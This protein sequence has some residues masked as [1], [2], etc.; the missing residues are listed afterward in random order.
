MSGESWMAP[1]HEFRDWL[2]AIREDPDMR[3]TK[4]R[5]G[6]VKP[7]QLGPFT[8]QARK[9][10]LKRLLQ[11]EQDVGRQ[12]ITDQEILYIQR[13]WT[14]DYD[15]AE[16]A[17]RLAEKFGRRVEAMDPITLPQREQEILE[18]LLAEYEIQPEL[19]YHLLSLVKHKYPSLEVWGAK[20]GL[21][22]DVAE[23]ITKV[24][25]LD[26]Q[27]DLNNAI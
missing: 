21:E 22:R 26:E 25:E 11:T 20:T 3:S 1:L 4:R 8:P 17:V 15:L 16:S 6:T 18:E 24:V 14:K 13:V 12:L 19:V 23:A 7:G 5:D 27:A 2:K 9:Q 10:I